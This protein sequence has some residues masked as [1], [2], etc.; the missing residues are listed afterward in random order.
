M[1]CACARKRYYIY[2]ILK[3]RLG[4]YISPLERDIYPV[5]YIQ[6]V[7]RV[8]SNTQGYVGSIRETQSIGLSIRESNGL[9]KTHKE[10][11]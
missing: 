3:Y 9:H 10:K 4:V 7:T 1:I 6:R 5:C 2:L 8:L 11:L